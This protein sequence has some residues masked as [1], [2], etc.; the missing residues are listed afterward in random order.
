MAKKELFF[1]RVQDPK[2][3]RKNLLEASQQMVEGMK[4]YEKYKKIKWEK[5]Q[6]LDTLKKTT[7]HIKELASQLRASLPTIK[8]A[9][10]MKRERLLSHT[11]EIELEQLN[12]EIKKLEE[13]LRF[14]K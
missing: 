5:L 3:V 8:G 1:I 7:V 11:A 2:E 14:V 4:S 10:D 6:K 13:D 12:A 9:P